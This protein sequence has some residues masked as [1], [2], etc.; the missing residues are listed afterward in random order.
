MPVHVRSTPG[1]VQP[2]GS[3]KVSSPADSAERE[4]EQTARRIMRMPMAQTEGAVTAKC[5]P[6][7]AR[8][9]NTIR[10]YEPVRIARK[11]EG[12]AR[13][14]SAVAS[15]ISAS[16][17]SGK[18]LPS[19]I[20][21][22]MEPRFNADF[23]QVRIHTGEQ[24]ATLN[25]QVSAQAF[26]VGNQVY[27]GRDRFQP[28]SSEGRELIAHELT[29]TIQQGAA[30]Q[31]GSV[32]RS[33]DVTV[34]ERNSPQ[35]QRLGISDALDY[36]AGRANNIPGFRM[37]TIILGVNPINMNRVE[38]SAAN[39][40]RAVVEFIPGGG[41]ITQ[42]LDNHGVFDRVGNWVEQQIRTLGMTGSVIRDAVNRFVDSL[43]WSDALNLGGVWDRAKRIFSEPIDRIISFVASLASGIIKFIKDA[44]LMPL[45]RLASDTRGWDLLC[46]ILGRNPITGEAVPRTADTLIGGFMKFIGQEEIW[47]NIKKGNAVA[48]AWAWFKGALEGLMGLVLAVPRKIIDTLTSLTIM[49][50]V[51][52]VGVF[53]KI[54]G[55][56]IDIA[57]NF[58]SWGLNQVIG[59]LEILFSVVAPGIMPYIKKAQAAFTTIVKDPIGFVGNLVRAGKRGFELFATNIVTHLKTALIKWLVGPL[60]EAG[61]YIPQSFSLIEI[62]KLV[63][64]VL[65]LT[66]QNIRDKLVKI[67]PEPI[68]AGLEKTSDI[69]VTL[70]KDGPAAA[71]EQI[72][73]ELSELKDQLIVQ[74]TQMISIEVVKAAVMKLVSMLNPAGA[75][76]QA[77]IAIYNTI[78]FFIQKI[79]QIAAVVASFID[80][81]AAIA[82]GQVD[83]AAKKVELTMANTLTVIIAFMAKFAGLGNIPDKLVGIVKKIRQPIDKGVDKI[84]AWLGK[85][86]QKLAGAAKAGLKRLLDW[87]KKK[88]PVN[89]GGEKHTLT[90]EGSGKSAKLVLCSTPEK[91]SVFLENAAEKK[92]IETAKRK[93]PIAKAI[94]HE[95]KV[96]SFLTNLK[97]YEKNAEAAAG[98]KTKEA[99]NLMSKLDVEMAALG[100]HIV[101]TLNDWK[102]A[103]ENI[104]GVTLPRGSFSPTQKRGIAEQHTN[105]DDLVRN[106]KGELVNLKTGLARRHV[107]SSHDMAKHYEGMLNKKKISEGKLLL[108]QRASITD[109]RTPVEELSQSG[110]QKAATNRYSKFFG[111]LRNM[112]IGDSRENSSI[113][114][115][116]DKG[117][118]EMAGQK[119]QEH[120][121]HVKRAWAFD[122]DMK[123]SGLDEE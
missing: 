57:G 112:F 92:S 75:V 32:R 116:I 100:T 15:G 37:F 103:D 17:S 31:D 91:P 41:L 77:I 83:A 6:H 61:V 85:M 108:E 93:I 88:V 12:T 56:Y 106:S 96:D 42:A 44:I 27:F 89:G 55:T 48:R 2:A 107:V 122:K 111:Y 82:A 52:V 60:A 49:D 45:A 11:Q 69:L 119:L 7:A 114:E 65:G 102:V 34:N 14:S 90:F 33:A 1:V 23:S 8:F 43:S 98:E 76:I 80:S 59:L 9:A 87:W 123:I 40:M 74:V 79:K 109:A 95:E 94:K 4:A 117:H 66:W 110:I 25:R 18:P 21:Q 81:I 20:R 35:V 113:Q 36:F 72:K 64:S 50:I 84:V 54:A 58:I 68:L 24:A 29:H 63:L 19:G 78:T 104:V 26:T 38:R 86:L 47:E 22:F 71:W 46:A 97:K 101:A 10:Q 115:Y 120:V 53:K 28:E 99:D 16:R 118:P 105:K 73:A 67:I 13:T 5:S 39:I 62:V 70:V 3:L 51:T 121:N 30:A